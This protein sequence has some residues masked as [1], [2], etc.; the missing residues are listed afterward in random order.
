MPKKEKEKGSFNDSF[1]K[2]AKAL[3]PHGYTFAI[4]EQP[5]RASDSKASF[6]PE[7]FACFYRSQAVCCHVNAV[8]MLQELIQAKNREESRLFSH[9]PCAFQFLWQQQ[10][11]WKNRK[12]FVI[13][14]VHLDPGERA[15]PLQ[16]ACSNGKK[17][18][19]G[20]DGIKRSIQMWISSSQAILISLDQKQLMNSVEFSICSKNKL[21]RLCRYE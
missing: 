4:D 14:S 6:G 11:V 17:L 12:P 3:Q 10:G 8:Y 5:T 21:E 9:V 15:Q 20:F 1:M 7:H 13:L 18:A 16:H 19:S 2:F